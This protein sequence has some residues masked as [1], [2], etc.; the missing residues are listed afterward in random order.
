MASLDSKKLVVR[1]KPVLS[2]IAHLKSQWESCF[3]GVEFHLLSVGILKGY[4][5]DHD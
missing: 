4:C 1:V 2:I 5:R 3:Y